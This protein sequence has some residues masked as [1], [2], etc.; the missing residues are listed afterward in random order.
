MAATTEDAMETNSDSI[1]PP[2]IH[3][4]ELTYAHPGSVPPVYLA[5]SFTSPPWEPQELHYTKLRSKDA[6]P[7]EEGEEVQLEYSFYKEFD[8]KEGH[9]QYKFRVGEGD[10]WVLDENTATVIDGDGN[11]VNSLFVQKSSTGQ[12]PE[13]MAPPETTATTVPSEAPGVLEPSGPHS[14]GSTDVKEPTN[15]EDLPVKLSEPD[16]IPPQAEVIVLKERDKIVPQDVEDKTNLILPG[17]EHKGGEL[18]GVQESGQAPSGD[19]HQNILGVSENGEVPEISQEQNSRVPNGH[20]EE[21]PLVEAGEQAGVE[22]QIMKPLTPLTPFFK[23]QKAP[24]SLAGYD[25]FPIQPV[26]ESIDEFTKIFNSGDGPALIEGS[27]ATKEPASTEIPDFKEEIPI[28]LTVVDKIPDNEQPTCRGDAVDD[29]RNLREV[30]ENR[31]ADSELDQVVNPG[32]PQPSEEE[33]PVQASEPISVPLPVVE[34]TDDKPNYDEGYGVDSSYAQKLANEKRAADMEPDE[35][36]IS[37]EQESRSSLVTAGTIT[38]NDER[39][40]ALK[41]EL[42][43]PKEAPKSEEAMLTRDVPKAEKA[44]ETAEAPGMAKAAEPEKPSEVV[45]A[46]V[47]EDSAVK[48]ETLGLE[49]A[50]EIEKLVE[51]EEDAGPVKAPE[52][53]KITPTEET[54]K[55]PGIAGVPVVEVVAELGGVLGT[56]ETLEVKEAVAVAEAAN[57][58]ESADAGEVAEP[59]AAPG[60]TEALEPEEAGTVAETVEATEALAVEEV[61]EPQAA[62]DAVEISEVEET[63]A[64]AETAKAAE[65]PVV[66]DTAELEAALGEMEV[67]EAEETVEAVKPPEVLAIGGATEPGAEEILEADAAPETEEA[68]EVTKTAKS[69]ETLVAMGVTE[70][71]AD[72]ALG[73]EETAEVAE[74]AKL[75]ET[76]VAGEITELESDAVLGTE[77]TAEVTEVAKPAETLV[78]REVT[79]SEVDAVPETETVGAMEAAKPLETPVAG[80]VT[81]TEVDAVPETEEAT[82]AKRPVETLTAVEVAEPEADAAPEIEEAVEVTE[83]AKPAEALVAGEVA[84][85]EVDAAPEIEE[86]VEVTEVA[87]PAETLV[88]GGVAESESAPAEVSEAEKTLEPEETVAAT[89]AESVGVPAIGD[90]AKP[91]ATPGTVG[92]PEV[93]EVVQPETLETADAAEATKVTE[94]GRTTGAENSVDGV[95]KAVAEL[96]TTV[97]SPDERETSPGAF[98]PDVSGDDN[99]T[100]RQADMKWGVE[101]HE[102][103]EQA[104]LN[105]I[106]GDKEPVRD[107]GHLHEF[108]APPVP[109]KSA[110]QVHSDPDLVE[111]D[112]SQNP[113]SGPEKDLEAPASLTAAPEVLGI[114]ENSSEVHETTGTAALAVLGDHIPAVENEL[115]GEV[116]VEPPEDSE[117]KSHVDIADAKKDFLDAMFPSGAAAGTSVVAALAAVPQTETTKGVA[118]PAAG[119]SGGSAEGDPTTELVK[120]I[121]SAGGP[122]TTEE[123]TRM[124]KLKGGDLA[125]I[126]RAVGV[127]IDA[128]ANTV[129]AKEEGLVVDPKV[130]DGSPEIKMSKEERLMAPGDVSEPPEMAT[131]V[132]NLAEVPDSNGPPEAEMLKEQDLVKP[133]DVNESLETEITKGGDSIKVPEVVKESIN[134][135]H[136]DLGARSNLGGAIVREIEDRLLDEVKHGDEFGEL[137]PTTSAALVEPEPAPTTSGP[138]AL[139]SDTDTAL[140]Q[141]AGTAIQP[142]GQAERSSYLPPDKGPAPGSECAEGKRPSPSPDIA[143]TTTDIAG[144]PSPLLSDGI[145]GQSNDLEQPPSLPIERSPN[146]SVTPEEEAPSSTS[147]APILPEVASAV[148]ADATAVAAAGQLRGPPGDGTS[149]VECSDDLLSAEPPGTDLSLARGLPPPVKTEKEGSATASFG[150]SSEAEQDIPVSQVSTL[151]EENVFSPPSIGES[152]S[153]HLKPADLEPA[154]KVHTTTDA[155][156]QPLLKLG[157]ISSDV[158]S[159]EST[160]ASG[161]ATLENA[162]T[163]IISAITPT[164]STVAL[165]ANAGLEHHGATSDVPGVSQVGAHAPDETNIPSKDPAEG[166]LKRKISLEQETTVSTANGDASNTISVQKDTTTFIAGAVIGT[167]VLVE[168]TISTVK[169][170]AKDKALDISQ[171]ADPNAVR[172]G[173]ESAHQFVMQ[174][175]AVVEPAQGQGEIVAGAATSSKYTKGPEHDSAKA[176][177]PDVVAGESTGADSGGTQAKPRGMDRAGG[178]AL[179]GSLR[180]RNVDNDAGDRPRTPHSLQS[181]KAPKHSN[182]FKTFWR[183]VFG[184]WIGGFFSKIFSN[185]R[186][187]A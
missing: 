100:V 28:P 103:L 18:V 90:A 111:A 38:K 163:A 13:H 137:A 166:E 157:S 130:T 123:I 128:P 178:D 2:R 132:E 131:E 12:A 47:V 85:L 19:H 39:S 171:N 87:K 17:H 65:V 91:E 129:I 122:Q 79:E 48:A 133:P 155:K 41:P 167:A 134:K 71:G 43:E 78:T 168:S 68:I 75:A 61:A 146:L 109:G 135:T 56:A 72:V 93:E 73:I 88:V 23:E 149:Q 77:E 179:G 158:T 42:L 30:V 185:K 148:P 175:H 186:H 36:L 59:E 46:L 9:W 4:V 105:H 31:Q 121:E 92:Y 11:R 181:T 110:S 145:S 49:E 106:P 99:P 127:P 29:A 177:A 83:A 151:P 117:S 7:D 70:P 55:E 147:H 116:S 52:V 81:E 160:R 159:D 154:A 21:Q 16:I 20:I 114:A 104:N 170:S 74:A 32:Q 162:T 57:P 8:V 34:K 45:E 25:V 76:L 80:G 98:G 153:L 54:A 187:R 22:Q 53:E 119:A 64:S 5:G 164:S 40:S 15:P 102:N 174:D 97:V 126:R 140:M 62:L 172:G 67:L 33:A 3:R 165:A 124:E 183:T 24:D 10:L 89:G 58:T 101:V 86:A 112:I 115:R 176:W 180:Q 60:T 26:E 107:A 35:I 94:A 37:P 184:G 173:V 6:G 82:V 27:S 118:F 161:P 150:A 84:E 95:P 139:I 144:P 182:I 141:P 1:S 113:I 120:D 138:S 50:P 125:E 44:P 66:G 14:S 156:V 136:L 51:R 143:D 108:R 152:L 96:T 63:V 69:V 169:A 142:D